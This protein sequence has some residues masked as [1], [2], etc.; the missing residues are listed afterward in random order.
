MFRRTHGDFESHH[1]SFGVGI[2]GNMIHRVVI[3]Q[4]Q[5]GFLVHYMLY[6][7]FDTVYF[8]L[9]F[10]LRSWCTNQ[11]ECRTCAIH[12]DLDRHV[13]QKQ[14]FCSEGIVI[15]SSI[16]FKTSATL[17]VLIT[18]YTSICWV[19]V[20]LVENV[21]VFKDVLLKDFIIFQQI[22]QQCNLGMIVVCT[23]NFNTID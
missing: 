18:N 10:V 19:L 5:Y 2:M 1:F 23:S 6:F 12:F 20:V 4:F 9:V 14:S 22:V 8:N 3:Q 16:Q 15:Q 21:R 11:A 13:W 17:Y 7:E